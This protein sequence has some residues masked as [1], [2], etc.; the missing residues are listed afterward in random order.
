MHNCVS[1]KPGFPWG[2]YGIR[3]P[4]PIVTA[5]FNGCGV[6]GEFFERAGV[7]QL[8]ADIYIHSENLS[9]Y[10]DGIWSMGF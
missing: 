1:R 9:G 10:W 4:H 2:D 5:G 8:Y 3:D 7:G 6:F